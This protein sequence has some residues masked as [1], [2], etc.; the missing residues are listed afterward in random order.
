MM[1]KPMAT[2]AKEPVFSMGDDT[3]LP[4]LARRPRPIHHYLRQ[5]F[6]QVTNPA[7]DHLRERLVMSLRTLL[8]PRGPLLSEAPEAAQLVELDSFFLFPGAVTALTHEAS[9]PFA[10]VRLEAT[11]PIQDGPGGLRAAI[12]RLATE[13][14]R[15]ASLGAHLIIIDNSGVSASRA[16]VP[17]LLATGAVHHDLIA[18]GHRP[19]AS[20]IVMADD[21]RDV[22]A[23]ACLVG[24]GADAVCPKLALETVAEDTDASEDSDLVSP[25]AQQRFQAAVEDGVLKIMSKMGIAT[26]DSYRGAQIF[27]AVGLDDEVVA[28]CF[29]GM[30]S[31]VGGVGWDALGLDVLNLHAGAEWTK[32]VAPDLVNPGY[33][34]DLKRGGE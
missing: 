4:P 25:E 14:S 16:P 29:A 13:A 12:D 5:R 26:V 15:A 7:I 17:S 8:G 27:E 9:A 22:H 3:P 33:Y 10:A 19:R 24:C 2:D 20:L 32:E 21:A 31:V 34:R 1:V 18:A 28:T 11:F 6:A 23:I 30:P